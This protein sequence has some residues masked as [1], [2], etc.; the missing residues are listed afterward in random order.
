MISDEFIDM[1]MHELTHRVRYS[2]MGN[3]TIIAP[4]SFQH[5]IL[6]SLDAKMDPLEYENLARYADSIRSG[7][8]PKLF[9]PVHINGNHWIP[10]CIDSSNRSITYSENEFCLQDEYQK[11]NRSY[12]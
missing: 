1:L 6:S 11:L 10:F 3:S 4:L 2:G 7:R 9:F 8:T 12:L 5:H